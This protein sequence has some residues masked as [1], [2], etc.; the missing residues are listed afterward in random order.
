MAGNRLIATV[1]SPHLLLRSNNIARFPS[2][3][4]RSLKI[5]VPFARL[6][7]SPSFSL[8]KQPKG[9]TPTSVATNVTIARRAGMPFRQS[10]L[11][12]C[13]FVAAQTN[14]E[15]QRVESD[16]SAGGFMRFGVSWGT[17]LFG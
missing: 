1:A 3:S 16:N 6:C 11:S 12:A 14:P 8:P 17:F 2:S 5:S 9:C 7:W 4:S 10:L 13:R 15:N